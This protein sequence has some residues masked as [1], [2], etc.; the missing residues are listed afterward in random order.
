MW[1]FN[2]FD[3]KLTEKVVLASK[4]Q[5]QIISTSKRRVDHQFTGRN[6]QQGIERE[7]DTYFD[8]AMSSAIIFLEQECFLFRRPVTNKISFSSLTEF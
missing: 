6:T 4:K 3:G 7:G 5:K 2:I 1:V 8:I